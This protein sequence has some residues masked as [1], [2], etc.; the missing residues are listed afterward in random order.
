MSTLSHQNNS[1][2][3]AAAANPNKVGIAFSLAASSALVLVLTTFPFTPPALGPNVALP[4]DS[5][6]VPV[7]IAPLVVAVLVIRKPC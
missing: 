6:P 4:K 2:P 5:V 1:P 7:A 3:R